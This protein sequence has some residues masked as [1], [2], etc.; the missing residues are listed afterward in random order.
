MGDGATLTGQALLASLPEP[1]PVSALAGDD[2]SRDGWTLV[3]VADGCGYKQDEPFRVNGAPTAVSLF[4]FVEVEYL[5]SASRVVNGGSRLEIWRKLI[6][7]DPTQGMETRS[8]KT[9]GLGPKDDSPVAESDA[10]ELG[11]PHIQGQG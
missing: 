5:A 3:G 9:E 7:Y 6:P 11:R 10:P 8:A 4:P 2:P 1:V